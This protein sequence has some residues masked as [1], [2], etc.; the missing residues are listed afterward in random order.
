MKAIPVSSS[1][2]LFLQTDRL[3]VHCAAYSAHNI[4]GAAKFDTGVILEGTL[5]NG[6]GGSFTDY[7]RVRVKHTGVER[8]GLVSRHVV[9]RA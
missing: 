6:M 7:I 8:E 4:I 9:K 5:E 3:T 2:I 1:K